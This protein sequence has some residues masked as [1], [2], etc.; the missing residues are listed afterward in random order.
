MINYSREAGTSERSIN[1]CLL[2]A[3]TQHEEL[4]NMGCAVASRSR[5]HRELLEEFRATKEM[6]A[7]HVI[8][9]WIWDA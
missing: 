2:P 4:L 7:G 5:P 1:Y 8:V 9:V 6:F 3:E